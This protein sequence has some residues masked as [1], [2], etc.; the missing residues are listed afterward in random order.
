MT[1]KGWID[2]IDSSARKLLTKGMARMPELRALSS[3]ETLKIVKEAERLAADEQD[4]S[5]YERATS[6]RYVLL[7][8]VLL[9][10]SS[11]LGFALFCGIGLAVGELHLPRR[12]AGALML[13]LAMGAAHLS[14]KVYRTP[15]RMR[16]YVLKVL[17]RRQAR[18]AA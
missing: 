3:E 5:L 12:A 10:L 8:A 14:V 16:P 4:V 1:P 13:A 9:L 18:K 17:E 15:R 6:A 7:F 11:I 2:P